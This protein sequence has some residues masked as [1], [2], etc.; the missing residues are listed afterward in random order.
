MLG[1]IKYEPENLL[2]IDGHITNKV[3]RVGKR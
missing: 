2:P 3:G 1:R